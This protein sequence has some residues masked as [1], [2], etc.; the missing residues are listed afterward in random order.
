MITDVNKIIREKLRDRF[1]CVLD[2]EPILRGIIY[3]VLLNGCAYIVGGFVRDVIN[4]RDSRDLDIIVDIPPSELKRIL[5]EYNC[6]EYINRLGGAKLKLQHVEVDVWA[7]DTNWAFANNLVKLNEN[8]KLN[9]IAKGCFY[10]YDALV[11]GI[12]KYMYSLKYYNDFL[13]KK[14][15]DIIQR[16]S[17]YKKLNP[18][19]E[20]NILR[21]IYI[22]KQYSIN[23]SKNLI[24]YLKSEILELQYNWGNVINRLMAM[25][26]LYPKYDMV[27]KDDIKS[28]VT[29]LFINALPSLFDE[30]NK[31]IFYKTNI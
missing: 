30:E 19:V 13:E 3:D 7:I 17:L 27:S 20:A 2:S 29:K 8:D 6:E 4:G 5:E 9:S 16:Q 24:D 23:Y 15:L 18:T 25:K 11:V 28:T 12:P 1:N 26:A 21:A 10:N 14:E 22:Q 31:M